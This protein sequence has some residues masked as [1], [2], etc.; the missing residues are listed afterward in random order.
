MG[1]LCPFANKSI[2]MYLL[3]N[4]FIKICCDFENIKKETARLLQR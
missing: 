4:G 3:M 1:Q 2:Y